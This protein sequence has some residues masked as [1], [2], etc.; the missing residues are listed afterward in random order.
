MPRSLSGVREGEFDTI[1]VTE[2]MTAQDLETQGKITAQDLET[3][4]SFSHTGSTAPLFNTLRVGQNPTE[5]AGSVVLKVDGDISCANFVTTGIEHTLSF[6][7][8]DGVTTK[9][10]DGST[11]VTLT[12]TEMTPAATPSTLTLQHGSTSVGTYSATDQTLTIPRTVVASL[13]HSS[14]QSID[15]D[16]APQLLMSGYG[17]TLANLPSNTQV[18]VDVQMWISN[19]TSSLEEVFLALTTSKT[20][21]V[22][23][24]VR[25]VFWEADPDEQGLATYSK[26]LTLSGTVNIGLAVD[27]KDQEYGLIVK[28]GGDF[29]DVVMSATIVDHTSTTYSSGG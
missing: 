14:A 17:I 29:P 15:I 9:T 8:A 5:P 24:Y 2:K 18:K 6:T 3:Q 28:L 10:Y 1:E 22:S 21:L 27:T 7:L 23:N 26:V 11:D 13:T 12:A 4:G 19:P 16:D 20:S 25:E